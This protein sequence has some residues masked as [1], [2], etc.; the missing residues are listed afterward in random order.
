MSHTALQADSLRPTVTA[1][2]LEKSIA[3][4]T[5]GLGFEVTHRGEI[6]GALRYVEMKAGNV[7]F[8]LGRD[9][10]KKGRD[11]VKGVGLR[12]HIDTSEDIKELADR[13]IKAG[14]TLDEG[15]APLPWGPM[16]FA[17]TDPD[18]FHLTIANPR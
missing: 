14:I 7:G 5:E 15:P 11:R 2:D 10:F 4:Y 17:V 9:D 3:F 8:V 13:A 6:E 16:A 18:G 12:F 1:T